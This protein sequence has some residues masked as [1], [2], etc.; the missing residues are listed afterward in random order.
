MKNKLIVYFV[1]VFLFSASCASAQKRVKSSAKAKQESKEATV[2]EDDKNEFEY[3]FIE[4]LKQKMIGNQQAAIALFSKC[5]EIN[6]NSSSAMFELAK[7]HSGNGDQTSAS[8]LLEKAINLS[9]ENKWYKLLLAQIYQQGKQYKKAADMYQQLYAQDPENLEYLYMNAALLSSA[10]KYDLALKAYNELEKKVGVNDQISVEKQQIYQAE[11]KK[12]EAL[13]E[14][15]KLIAL[16]PK[17]PRYYGLLADFYLSEKDDAN[18]LKNYMKI[19][20]IDPDNGFVLFSLASYYREKGDKEKSWEY[21]RKGFGNKTVEVDTKIQYYL[22]MTAD[23]EKPFFTDDQVNELVNILVN[24]NGDDYRV[25]TVYAEYLIRKGKLADA[26][27]QLRQVLQNEKDNYLIWER[28]LMISNDLQD[29][30]SVYTD[31][32][33]ALELFPS[34]PVLYGLKAVA[35]LQLQKYTEAL[36]VLKEGEPYLLDNKPL[37][38]Q[39][40]LYRAEANYKLNKVEEAFKSFDTV[41]SLDP[42]NYLAMNNYAYYLS[43]R[44]EDLEKAE[45]L[46]GRAVKA[47]PDNAT[48][49]DTYAWVLFMRKDYQLAKFYMEIAI[50]NGG[51]KNGTIVEH[52]GDIL[53]MLGEKDEA[54]DQWKKALGTGESSEFLK[55]KIKQGRYIDK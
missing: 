32:D 50:K 17:E 27:E 53:F 49:L 4:A 54:L 31:A 25:Y 8:L 2:S 5:M 39:F 22:M 30:Q 44:N 21:V 34:Q 28:M 1:V 41:I 12:K 15:K 47:N 42:E 13:A 7:I 48:Y 46:S 43:L 11:G 40:E 16:N 36:A 6:P 45:L 9:P 3:T 14:L 19:L 33:K 10:E 20:E 26:R 23:P 38:I 55:E 35:C 18:A 51:D 52:Y 24:T 29:F 37:K